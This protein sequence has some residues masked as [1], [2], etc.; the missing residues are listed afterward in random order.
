M[1]AESLVVGE[2][3][4]VVGVGLS[5]GLVERRLER[6]WSKWPLIMAAECGG[7]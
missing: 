4:D 6:C 7:N 2:L 1:V 3:E 5:F